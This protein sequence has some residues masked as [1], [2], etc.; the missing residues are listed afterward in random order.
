[1][2]SNL[3][4]AAV[5][6]KTAPREFWTRYHA[7]RQLRHAEAHP[8]DPV[9]PDH[10][11]EI[12]MKHVKP[13]EIQYRYEIAR[14][15]EML[16]DFFA[17]TT[18][19]GSPEYETNKQFMWVAVSVHPDH[20]RRGIGRSW[21]PLTLELMERHGCTTLTMASSEEP[22]HEFLKSIGAE[23]KSAGA[24]NRLQLADVDWAMLQR[25]VDDGPVKSPATR[26]EVYDGHL[27][28]EMWEDYCPQLSALLN[29]MPW[30]DLDHG[31]IVVTPAQLADWHVRLDEQGGTENTMLTREPDGTIS[32]ITD[33]TFAPYKPEF[34]EQGFTGVRADARGR[35]LGKWLK[36]AML[37]H[38]RDIYPDLQTVITG[39]A[40]SNEPMLA[41]NK[42]MGFKEHRAGN[43]YQ[44]TLEKLREAH[45]RK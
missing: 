7:Y 14:D 16:S 30:D 45:K 3:S 1:M 38:V 4:P 20:R 24:E 35:G 18:K 6:T 19:P 5:D 31:D 12:E 41:I 26:L 44:I 32:G 10:L 11:V 22:G 25:W 9:M 40:S 27:P 17:A 8:G 42:K 2:I 34:I 39:N 29:T 13:F 33:M 37:L 36:A 23:G 43:D 15:G 21:I 28:A